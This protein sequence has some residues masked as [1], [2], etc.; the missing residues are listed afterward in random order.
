VPAVALLIVAN[1]MLRDRDWV[2]EWFW[3]YFNFHF[4]SVFL[5]PLAAGLAA[6]EG[7]RFSRAGDYLT[8]ADGVRRALAAAASAVLGWLLL[9]YL[10]GL[11][12]ISVQVIQAGTPGGPGLIEM[13]TLIPALAFLGMWTALGAAAGYR[14]RSPL[15]APLATVATFSIILVLYMVDYDLVRV[16][17]ATGSLLGLAPRPG[18]QVAQAALYLAVAAWA[19]IRSGQSGGVADRRVASFAI[20]GV[21][22]VLAA[23]LFIS[24]GD[25]FA[26]RPVQLRCEGSPP[27][28]LAPGYD[29]D[30]R[31]VDRALGPLLEGLATVGAPVPKRFVQ[32]YDDQGDLVGSVSNE[33]ALGDASEARY[34]I[35]S[36]FLGSGCDLLGDPAVHQ[37]WSGLLDW[38]DSLGGGVISPGDPT[39]PEVLKSGSPEEQAAWIRD[40]VGRM[41]RCG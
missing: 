12:W 18:L 38:L 22:T 35:A 13:S 16:G 3:A 8:S 23:G 34:A 37:A 17:G 5:G 28:C 7:A 4:V 6:W 30:R 25:D 33:L 36:A 40:A 41:R 24:Q 21:A 32:D 20:A 1:V 2:H 31:A 14:A 26:T 11:V 29:G 15:A 19:I 10:L 9:P 39:V 27:V